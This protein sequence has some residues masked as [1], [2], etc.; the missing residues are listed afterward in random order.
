M[1]RALVPQENGLNTVKYDVNSITNANMGG[2]DVE[3]A[4]GWTGG[5]MT[6]D[7]VLR[8]SEYNGIRLLY[9]K[10]LYYCQKTGTIYYQNLTPGAE[11]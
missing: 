5:F 8:E 11:I 9:A 10:A 2:P 6:I 4:I 3:H 7:N 1:I